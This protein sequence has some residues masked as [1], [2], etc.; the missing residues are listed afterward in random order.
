MRPWIIMAS[1]VAIA[2]LMVVILAFPIPLPRQSEH[3]VQPA[4]EAPVPNALAKS[5]AT[6]E[7]QG[8]VKLNPDA[9]ADQQRWGFACVA[10]LTAPKSME[11]GAAAGVETT[12]ITAPGRADMANLLAAARNAA[13]AI[14]AGTTIPAAD[15]GT[16]ID[17]AADSVIRRM[18]EENHNRQAAVDT[19]PGSPIM[20][21]HLAGPGF[22]I[23]P[24]TPE[25]QAISNRE[26]AI[27]AWTIK[28]ID[29]GSRILT[30]SYNAEVLVDGQRLPQALRTISRDV[31]V[32][33]GTESLLDRID[34]QTKAAKSIAE[35]TS[36]FWT[37]LVFPA[38]MFV[39]GLRKW[40]RE[41]HARP[42]SD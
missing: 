13:D 32:S 28:A 2:A 17:R 15:P 31:M 41:R 8:G 1:A 24:I 38:L 40:T 25:R 9:K 12:L 30:V 4:S 21:V 23:T 18:V 42:E 16:G 29:A 3:A 14:N 39:Y 35:N 10:L 33:V 11:V 36:W 37:T 6:V 27:W 19:L 20:T 34:K 22:E 26:P 5:E 7:E